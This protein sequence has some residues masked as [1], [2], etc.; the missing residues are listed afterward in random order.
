MKKLTGLIITLILLTGCA[1]ISIQTADSVKP[2]KPEPIITAEPA[3]T[4]TPT[5]NVHEEAKQDETQET[6]YI[7]NINTKK[8]HYPT[9]TGAKQIKDKNK[10]ELTGSRDELISQGYEPCK[11]CKP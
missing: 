10:R 11:M 9:C 5:E 7:L 4:E 1:K 8:F 2:Q 3:Q 6:T